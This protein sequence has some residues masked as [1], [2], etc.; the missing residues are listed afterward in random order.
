MVWPAGEGSLVG[1]VTGGLGVVVLDPKILDP[2]L[3]MEFRSVGRAGAV[4]D[5]QREFTL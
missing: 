5:E 1:L 3:G 4:V 2:L